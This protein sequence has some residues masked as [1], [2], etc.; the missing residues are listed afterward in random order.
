MGDPEGMDVD[1]IHGDKLD[2]RRCSL[3]VLTRQQNIMASGPR[4]RAPSQYKGV[5]WHK[6]SRKW[7]AV[8]NTRGYGRLGQ[9]DSEEAAARA[10]DAAARE[11]SPYAYQNFRSS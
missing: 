1:R 8:L 5:T 4:K 2:N 7:V 9:F 11:Y 10:Y 6:K 3:R